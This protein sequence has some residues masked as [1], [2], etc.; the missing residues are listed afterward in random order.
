MDWLELQWT[1]VNS[2][3]KTID[4]LSNDGTRIEIHGVKREVKL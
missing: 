4:F 1:L 2:K 3:D